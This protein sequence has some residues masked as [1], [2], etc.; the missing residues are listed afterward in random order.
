MAVGGGF[1][2]EPST[3]QPLQAC[4]LELWIVSLVPGEADSDDP[5]SRDLT[6]VPAEDRRRHEQEDFGQTLGKGEARIHCAGLGSTLHWS[7]LPV[8][9][10]VSELQHALCPNS[11]FHRA[12]PRQSQ[13]RLTSRPGEDLLSRLASIH[14]QTLKDVLLRA[15]PKSR[16]S[17]LDAFACMSSSG[18]F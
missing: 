15:L 11:A 12:D 13:I 14:R 10:P 8:L 4:L 5:V 9:P 2:Q 18:K 17:F 16:C 6:S 3:Q 1:G 7:L